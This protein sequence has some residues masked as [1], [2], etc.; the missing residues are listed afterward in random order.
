MGVQLHYVNCDIAR[1]TACRKQ[2]ET[3][4]RYRRMLLEILGVSEADDCQSRC[5][6]SI[7]EKKYELISVR[8]DMRRML[9][10]GVS[11]YVCSY[12]QGRGRRRSTS[13]WNMSGAEDEDGLFEDVDGKLLAAAATAA[14]A[15]AA[16]V[17][18]EG[19]RDNIDAL[20]CSFPYAVQ[21]FTVHPICL[22]WITKPVLGGAL[23]PLRGN[24]AR[25]GPG[26]GSGHGSGPAR[27]GKGRLRS[28]SGL[29]PARCT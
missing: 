11:R 19:Q 17:A 10:P 29:A 7:Y 6:R 22:D 9:V 27:S 23:A 12:R 3:I 14:D 2:F 28:G 15:A 16:A 13:Y 18:E 1:I 25:P 20:N 4:I 21:L 8:R 26:P 5:E 24:T